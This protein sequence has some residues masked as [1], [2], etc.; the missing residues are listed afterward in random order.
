MSIFI[1]NEINRIETIPQNRVE[2]AAVLRELVEADY[3]EAVRQ[4]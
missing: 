3:E 2:S 4:L 1:P